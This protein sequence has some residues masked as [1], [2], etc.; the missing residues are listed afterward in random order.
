M[1]EKLTV[2][3]FKANQLP[4]EFTDGSFVLMTCQRTLV[5]RMDEGVVC[6]AD[7]LTYRGKQAYSFLL[8]VL[9]GLHSKVVAETEI[10]R[11]FKKAYL[12]YSMT[13]QRCGQL[14]K[15]IERLFQD[16]K[17]IRHR[18]LRTVSGRSYA[19]LCRKIVSK[20]KEVKK[21]LII[22]SGEL[23]KDLIKFFQA[24]FP[25]SLSARNQ[26]TAAELAKEFCVELVEWKNYSR[27]QE[28]SCVFNTVGVDDSLF[29]HDFFE[30]WKGKHQSEKVFV[31]LG[32]PSPVR[33]SFSSKE[34][35]YRLED[36]L[37]LADE[38]AENNDVLIQK[39]KTAILERT[40]FRS[41]YFQGKMKRRCCK[42]QGAE[43]AH[44]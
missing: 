40:Q 15:V 2:Y 20:E 22:G 23:A 36:I 27:W 18:F 5:V 19:S 43:C 6:S 33:T 41:E 11:Q 13:D 44:L 12:D 3:H 28:F 35:V 16:A 17:D 1:L 24:T 39:A 31:D 34:G 21:A 7:V 9:C 14:M 38:S 37:Q 10:I 4:S 30:V 42:N 25:L 29:D 32:S 26:V 8:E